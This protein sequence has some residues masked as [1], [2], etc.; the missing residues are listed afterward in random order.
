MGKTPHP[1]PCGT[2]KNFLPQ[3]LTRLGWLDLVE[4]KKKGGGM[5]NF[6]LGLG[7]FTKIDYNI[8]INK[9]FLSSHPVKIN[10][11]LNTDN[12]VSI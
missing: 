1:T 10:L 9:H 7:S 12:L 11:D 6:W 2:R 8:T 4:Q 3:T 5:A